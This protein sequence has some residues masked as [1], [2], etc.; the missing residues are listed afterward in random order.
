M[1]PV[2]AASELASLIAVA[3]PIL[4]RDSLGPPRPVTVGRSSTFVCVRDDDSQQVAKRFLLSSISTFFRLSG[5]L[6][7]CLGLVRRVTVSKGIVQE[8]CYAFEAPDDETVRCAHGRL[9][10]LLSVLCHVSSS[11]GEAPH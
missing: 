10:I 7:H 2:G 1:V 9:L 8:L 3:L 5:R 11:V 6:S 4:Q